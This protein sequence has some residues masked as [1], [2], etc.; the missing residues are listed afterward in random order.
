MLPCIRLLQRIRR[1]RSNNCFPSLGQDL[2]EC[3]DESISSERLAEI[4]EETLAAP[5]PNLREACSRRD[6]KNG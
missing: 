4:Q 5:L 1:L 3:I 2:R 6:L